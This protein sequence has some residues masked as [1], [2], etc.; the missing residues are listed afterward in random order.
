MIQDPI[1]NHHEHMIFVI[2]SKQIKS[3]STFS[4]KY[5]RFKLIVTIQI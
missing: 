3:L 5:K 2:I 1:V 4:I